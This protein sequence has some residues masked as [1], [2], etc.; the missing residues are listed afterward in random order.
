MFSHEAAQVMEEGAERKTKHLHQ[1][2]SL[3]YTL[4]IWKQ[5]LINRHIAFK[6]MK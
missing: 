6:Y 3:K 1:Q 5:K 2:C 4:T